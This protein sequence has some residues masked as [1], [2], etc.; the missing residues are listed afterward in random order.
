MWF[1]LIIAAA[2]YWALFYSLIQDSFSAKWSTLRSSSAASLSTTGW[3]IGAILLGTILAIWRFI[4]RFWFWMLILLLLF[5]A[6]ETAR[7]SA[8]NDSSQY[9]PS[10]FQTVMNDAI[11]P[12]VHAIGTPLRILRPFYNAIVPWTNALGGMHRILL[13]SALDIAQECQLF[14][15]DEF[16]QSVG[17]FFSELFFST[18]NFFAAA[19][20]DRF[21]LFKPLIHARMASLQLLNILDCQ[22]HRARAV[23]SVFEIFVSPPLMRLL[24]AIFNLLISI[25]LWPYQIVNDILLAIADVIFGGLTFVESFE[26]WYQKPD[27]GADLS[28]PLQDATDAMRYL[29]QVSDASTGILLEVTVGIPRDEVPGFVGLLTAR[30]AQ[31]MDSAHVFFAAWLRYPIRAATNV[32]FTKYLGNANTQALARLT[33]EPAEARLVIWRLSYLGVSELFRVE[34]AK[35]VAPLHD[36]PGSTGDKIANVT[37]ALANSLTGTR[38]LLHG[39]LR[40]ARKML[41]VFSWAHLWPKDDV[42]FQDD[43]EAIFLAFDAGLDELRETNDDRLDSRSDLISALGPGFVPVALV[44]DEARHVGFAIIDAIRLSAEA[45]RTNFRVEEGTNVGTNAIRYRHSAAYL[46]SIDAVFFETEAF[47]ISLANLVR[48]WSVL[49][50]LPK[51]LLKSGATDQNWRERMGLKPLYA[52]AD[53]KKSNNNKR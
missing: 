18:F 45:A 26:N 12:V 9:D 4:V 15:G 38:D 52:T 22:C 35:A 44:M 37:E 11:I 39:M 24:D 46:S 34:V 13:I 40:L 32:F 3:G 23:W 10:L 47:M 28:R 53:G 8:V 51:S 41:H 14:N 2:F 49:D 27:R 31:A 20:E 48:S 33:L 17:L 43:R 25:T 16:Q 1:L 36:N 30:L 5:A 21:D 29:G 19:T 7:I 50:N 6:A 42:D